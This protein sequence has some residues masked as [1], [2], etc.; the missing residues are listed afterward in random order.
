VNDDWRELAASRFWLAAFLCGTDTAQILRLSYR[1][2]SDHTF[3]WAVAGR[4]VGELACE[5][6]IRTSVGHGQVDQ[7]AQ[8][9]PGWA[10]R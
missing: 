5:I 4:S 9:D 6:A 8:G 7:G 10:L 2:A 1:T 3:V